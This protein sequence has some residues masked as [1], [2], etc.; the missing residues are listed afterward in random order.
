MN[1]ILNQRIQSVRAGKDITHAQIVAK[2][3]LREELEAEMEKYLARGGQI[4][5]AEQK[6]YEAKHGTNA[7]YTNMGC[8]C[9]KCHAWAL[10]AKKVKTGEIRL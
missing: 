6:P 2:R 10:K 3:N 4:K 1:E 8:R 7:Q 9:K 5:Q